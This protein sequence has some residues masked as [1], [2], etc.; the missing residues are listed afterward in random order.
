[1]KEGNLSDGN[2]LH[3]G[4]GIAGIEIVPPPPELVNPLDD[5]TRMTMV[6]GHRSQT[7]EYLKGA[8]EYIATE[9]A[10]GAGSPVALRVIPEKP[11]HR[12]VCY[13]SLVGKRNR[14]IAEELGL[15]VATVSAVLRQ[16]WARK[17][18]TDESRHLA[19]EQFFAKLKG[20]VDKSISTLVELRD[21]EKVSPAVRAS[22]SNSIVDR[23]LGKAIQR[24]EVERVPSITDAANEM[25]A[26]DRELEALRT[27]LNERK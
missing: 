3:A 6:N 25:S 7:E 14:E 18:M 4:S 20:E 23:V 17:F 27:Q 15:T 22:V 13:M 8:R 12:M 10:I 16:P 5:K 21:D 2:Q 9:N 24:T 19:Q 26:L 11:V 1:M